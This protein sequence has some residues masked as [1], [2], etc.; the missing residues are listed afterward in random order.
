[1]NAIG[2]QIEV[3]A[4]ENNRGQGDDTGRDKKKTLGKNEPSGKLRNFSGM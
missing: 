1:L 2:L 3:D 4:E